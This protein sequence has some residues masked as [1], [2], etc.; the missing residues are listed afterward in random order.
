MGDQQICQI[1]QIYSICWW[2]RP[3]WQPHQRHGP[4]S[5]IGG[6]G[7]THTPLVPLLPVFGVAAR[8]NPISDLKI[9]KTKHMAA[10]CCTTRHQRGLTGPISGVFAPPRTKYDAYCSRCAPPAGGTQCGNWRVAGGK[11]EDGGTQFSQCTRWAI[12]FTA[13][14]AAEWVVVTKY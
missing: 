1:Y 13:L 3:M 7:A 4:N 6:P 5:N 2:W 12:I 11:C 8:S 9:G 10:S 14:Q